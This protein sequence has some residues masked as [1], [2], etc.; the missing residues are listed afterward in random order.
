MTHTDR[1][2]EDAQRNRFRLSVAPA[3]GGTVNIAH[4]EDRSLIHKV[5]RLFLIAVLACAGVFAASPAMADTVGE[6]YENKILGN[7]KNEGT[8]LAGVQL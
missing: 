4:A 8:P 1:V 6:E 2:N 7:V 3:T 5:V